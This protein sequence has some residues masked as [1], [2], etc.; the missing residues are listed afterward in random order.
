MTNE[1]V[2]ALITG[3]G[4]AIGR[5]VAKALAGKHFQVHA[6]D[7]HEDRLHSLANEIDC[8]CHAID[9]TDTQSLEALMENMEVD[10]L[11]NNA[12]VLP[13]VTTLDA[14][15]R[16]QLDSLIDVNLRAPC[17]LTRLVLPGMLARNRGHIF[18]TGSSSAFTPNPNIA[19]YAA[20]K[21]AIHMLCKDIRFDLI[22][23]NIRVTEIAPGRVQSRLYEDV[24]G[25][26]EANKRLYDNFDAIQPEDL[27]R[28]V[29]TALDMPSH[30]DVTLFEVFPT[31]QQTGGTRTVVKDG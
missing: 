27:A 26:Q 14:L 3:A 25:E 18:M 15:T 31:M 22:G 5:A 21:A 17:H 16:D 24:F 9:I 6:L 12:G 29:I 2:T 19:V 8:V 13:A 28:L 7:V 23:K 20:T 30:C 4:S 1:L 10:V 11:V